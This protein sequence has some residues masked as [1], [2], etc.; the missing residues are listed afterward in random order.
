MKSRKK[1]NNIKVYLQFPWKSSDSSYYKN[2]M[3]FPPKKTVFLKKIKS[4]DVGVK[5][6]VPDK[7]SLKKAVRK[8]V[9]IF[10]IP[11]IT[12]SKESSDII[13]C[14]HCLSINK[15]PWVVDVEHYSMFSGGLGRVTRSFI[16]KKII[17]HF[18]RKRECTAI[19]PWTNK[20]AETIKKEIQDSKINK[21]IKVVYPAVHPQKKKAHKRINLLFIGRK[22]DGK[23]GDLAIEAMNQLTKKHKDVHGIFISE[24]PEKIKRKYSTNKKIKFI[25][26]IN[27]E[28]LFQEIYPK[29]DIL[30]YPSYTD[31]FGFAILEAMSFGV[32]S[33]CIKT[34]HTHSVDELIGKNKRGFVVSAPG[35]LNEEYSLG[36][37]EK[38]EV[39]K[40][41][42]KKTEELIKNQELRRWMSKKC[43]KEVLDGK[44]SIEQRNK[45]LRKIYEDALNHE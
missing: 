2:L 15:R 1:E 37:S 32:P 36:N 31:T 10:K 44:F 35:E 24:T 19:L 12:C 25:S 38:A 17:S 41:I 5:S 6:L 20:A 16:G 29:S 40:K 39:L 33:V 23:G 30:I 42:V 14:A 8:I 13:H 43:S 7:P 3:D 4:K 26:L 22:F 45:I 11:N 9:Q 28:K 34:N 27:Q 18:L 21:K